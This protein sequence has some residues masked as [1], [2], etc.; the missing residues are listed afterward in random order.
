MLRLIKAALVAAIGLH[1]LFY[2][3]QNIA[4]LEQAHA[5]LAYVFSNADH[6]AYPNTLFFALESPA[7]AWLGLGIVL[8]GEFA[9]GLLGL[10]G[11]WDLFRTRNA[12]AAEFHAAKRAGVIAAALALLTWFGIFM[13]FGAAFFQMWQTQVGAG[14][15]EGAFM[16]AMA[17]AITMLFVC[18][19]PDD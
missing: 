11:G 10:K 4:N 5:A 9:T 16:Y 15:M 2:A 18:L 13:T 14:S 17:S 12:A 19:T 8:V 1:A 6:E 3:L 7:M